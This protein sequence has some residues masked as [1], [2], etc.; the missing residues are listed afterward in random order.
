MAHFT[1]LSLGQVKQREAGC[2]YYCICSFHL[3]LPFWL[4]VAVDVHVDEDA[5]V[6]V[7]VRVDR[8]GAYAAV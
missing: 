7:R 5:D 2:F 4:P 3:L 6:S 1:S 8:T